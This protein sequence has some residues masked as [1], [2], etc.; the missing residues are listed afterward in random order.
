MNTD[1]HEYRHTYEYRHTWIQTHKNLKECTRVN[2]QAKKISHMNSDTHEYRHTWIIN[3]DTHK[4]RINTDKHTYRDTGIQR[5]PSTCVFIAVTCREYRDCR[6][7]LYCTRIAVN[8]PAAHY[9]IFFWFTVHIWISRVTRIDE[10]RHTNK[11]VNPHTW[12]Q[13]HNA[14]NLPAAYYYIVFEKAGYHKQLKTISLSS[15][16]PHMKLDLLMV[17]VPTGFSLCV[18]YCVLQCVLQCVMHC[19][20]QCVLQCVL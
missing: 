17:P 2:W 6:Q 19:V 11:H 5:L 10:S 7:P 4:C 12:T 3:T 8:L 14:V 18:L 13:T 9:R 15:F 1:T 16:V 20:L